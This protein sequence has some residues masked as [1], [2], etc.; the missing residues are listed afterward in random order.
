M[1]L[2]AIYI[3]IQSSDLAKEQYGKFSVT[4][5]KKRLRLIE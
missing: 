4:K 2:Q 1:N 5:K 3:S